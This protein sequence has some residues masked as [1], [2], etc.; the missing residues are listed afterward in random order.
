VFS[1]SHII[2]G[3]LAALVIGVSKSALP[4]TGLLATPL[5]ATIVS[6]RMIAGLMLPL[7]LLADVFAVRWYGKHARRD[8][9]TPLIPAVV[10]GFIAGTTFYVVLGAGGRALEITLG[11]T[12]LVFSI[13]QVA[14]IIRAS[15]PI[16]ATP[17]LT[18]VVGVVG[19]F[20]T[21]V[22]NSA[23][24][25]LNTYLSGIGLEK[26]PLIGTSA[27][28]Y[29]AVNMAKVPV[30]LAIGAWASGGRFF[31]GRTLAFDALVA[32]AVIAG[33]LGGRAMLPR[34]PQRTF[35]IVVLVLAALAALKLISGI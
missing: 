32:P 28:F 25:V 12:I 18:R 30:Y 7:L 3:L 5:L 8:L 19:G 6:G 29:F 31:T 27:W 20:T 2:V 24:P 21:F 16:P 15:P 22:S 35:T 9:L 11:V 23:G 34:I 13:A 1:A 14:K 10:V 33:V 4:G 26:E 17:S